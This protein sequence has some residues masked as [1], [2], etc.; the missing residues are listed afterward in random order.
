MARRYGQRPSAVLGIDDPWVA[1]QFD[2]TVMYVADAPDGGAVGSG[3]G[4]PAGGQRK[5]A[6]LAGGLGKVK[7]RKMKIPESGI[8]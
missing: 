4:A 8:W 7:V 1:Y 2:L 6:S 5:F 3:P